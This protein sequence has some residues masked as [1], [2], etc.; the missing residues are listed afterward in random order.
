M[1]IPKNVKEVQR[2]LGMVNYYRTHIPN[3]AALAAPLYDL[4][5]KGHKFEWLPEHER[6]IYA[7]LDLYQKRLALCPLKP[8]GTLELYTDASDIAC[9]AVILQDKKPIE[10]YS[11][12]FTPAEQRYSCHER[13][14]Y[15]LVSSVL[16]FRHI[17]I[18]EEFVVYTDH[19]PLVYWLHRPPVNER[20]A[21]WLVKIQ[22]LHFQI[23]YI[24]GAYNFIA[25]VLSR[26]KGVEKVTYQELYEHMKLNAIQL[27]F[28][29]ED[30]KQEQTEE[31]LKTCKVPQEQIE[32]HE[33]YKYYNQNGNLKLIIPPKFVYQIVSE[34]HNVGH[35]GRRR[36]IRAVSYNYF[37]PT[38]RVDVINFIK[39]CKVCGT[40]K[41]KRGIARTYEKFPTTSRFRT[42][43]VDIVGPLPSS[44]SGKQYIFTMIDRFSRFMEAVP[45]REITAQ[46]CANAFYSFWVSRYG[47]P[48][49]IVSDKGTQFESVLFNDM[50]LRLGIERRAT[51]AYHPQA[52]GLIERAHATLKNALRCI[53]TTLFDWE[54]SLPSALLAM[55]TAINDRGVS[56]SLVVYGEQ[57]TVPGKLFYQRVSYN[58]QCQTAF[59][60]EL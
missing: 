48:D 40:Q 44:Y 8:K 2:F 6:S 14:T 54:K 38:L 15:A 43:H 59:V 49:T 24:E 57:I 46:A 56:P 27:H 19:K 36:T 9:G 11:K 51:T 47:L 37:W 26:P 42:V 53:S 41:S 10:Y 32:T 55:R 18:G 34:V 3:L 12:K 22:G 17:L 52:N 33:G 5:Q 35:P 28:L 13:E 30:L 21:R 7:I 31:F 39:A 25:D 4:C 16:H 23:K 58:E 60:E 1:A 20:H 45:L 50:L 29:T